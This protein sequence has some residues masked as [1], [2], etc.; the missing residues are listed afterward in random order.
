MKK[1]VLLSIVFCFFTQC[2]SSKGIKQEDVVLESAPPEEYFKIRDGFVLATVVH[3]FN[4]KGC[5]VLLKV[6]NVYYQVIDLDSALNVNKLKIWIKFTPSRIVLKG[7]K[8]GVP[9]VLNEVYVSEKQ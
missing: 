9:I 1:I 6:E 3:D 8:M 4:E 2:K 7:C 5:P